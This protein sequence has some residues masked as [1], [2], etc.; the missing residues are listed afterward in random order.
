MFFP[1]GLPFVSRRVATE[2]FDIALI[3][4]GE[5]TDLSIFL[6]QIYVEKDINDCDGSSNCWPISPITLASPST[7]VSQR[8]VLRVLGW[9][10]QD[11]T[12]VQSRS[13]SPVCLSVIEFF[14]GT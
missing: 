10:A 4:L 8:S 13:L 3:K 12:G 2:V 11:Q 14:K 7:L 1:Q 6:S 9:G 5:S